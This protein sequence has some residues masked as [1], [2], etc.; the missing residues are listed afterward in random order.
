MFEYCK[1]KHCAY[2]RGGFCSFLSE[3]CRREINEDK[4]CV[5]S[6]LYLKCAYAFYSGGVLR[7]GADTK[8]NKRLVP[9][10]PKHKYEK[11]FE[12]DDLLCCLKDL[13]HKKSRIKRKSPQRDDYYYA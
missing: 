8:N 11:K 5:H 10:L 2:D 4:Q 13:I 3:P 9:G 12:V 7:C 1:H 6:G